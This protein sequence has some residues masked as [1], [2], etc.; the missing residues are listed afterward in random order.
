MHSELDILARKVGEAHAE[1]LL[2]LLR[3]E[4]ALL[5]ITR[6]RVTKHGDYRPPQPGQRHRLSLNGDMGPNQF[7]LTF[8]HEFAHLQAFKQYGHQIQPHGV[9]WKRIF[10]ELLTI[11][12]RKKAFPE[13][14]ILHILRYAQNPRASTLSDGKL[15][16][17]LQQ[18]DGDADNGIVYLKDIPLLSYFFLNGSYYHKGE[19]RRT[20]Y[21]C[22]EVSSSRVYL[23]H[24]LAEV[25]LIIRK[26]E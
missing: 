10:S 22:R 9:E 5:T 24:A 11:W 8:L 2:K 7:L 25:K 1:E 26:L 20:R 23:V 18:A 19:K 17:A 6:G 13:K 15:F 14:V 12:I 4:G 16:E 21:V 3:Q